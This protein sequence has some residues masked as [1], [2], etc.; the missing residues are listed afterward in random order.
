MPTIANPIPDLEVCDVHNSIDSDPRNRLAQN[1]S[2]GD[3]DAD[4]LDGRDPNI[5]LVSYH[6]TLQDAIDNISPL[7]KTNYANDPLTTNAS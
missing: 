5:F 6:K 7:S 4:V 3:R 1:I 2:L